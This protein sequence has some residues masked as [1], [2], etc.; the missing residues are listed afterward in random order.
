MTQSNSRYNKKCPT[1][2]A[3]KG[4]PCKTMTGAVMSTAIHDSRKP[5]D[6]DKYKKGSR[7]A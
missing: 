5:Y 6:P 1:C 4:K 3:A 2:G 7:R